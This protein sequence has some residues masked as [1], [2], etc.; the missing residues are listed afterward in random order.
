M[1]CGLLTQAG[2]RSTGYW[3]QINVPQRQKNFNNVETIVS[4]EA[5]YKPQLMV[6]T[7]DTDQLS[8]EKAIEREDSN[9]WEWKG[10][11]TSVQRMRSRYEGGMSKE[12]QLTV[13]S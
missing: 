12:L 3:I 9:E 6:H 8:D 2:V 13:G 5:F 10:M 7:W 1:N 11:E 4:A